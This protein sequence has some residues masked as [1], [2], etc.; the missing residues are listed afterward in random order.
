MIGRSG[1]VIVTPRATSY[2][3]SQSPSGTAS[4]R[5]NK[6]MM[7]Q[8]QPPHRM[9]TPCS[10]KKKQGFFWQESVGSLKQPGAG[11][12]KQKSKQTNIKC[13][14]KM[15]RIRRHI[16]ILVNNR[17]LVGGKVSGLGNGRPNMERGV[18]CV[19]TIPGCL[20]PNSI[21]SILESPSIPQALR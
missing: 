5:Q 16:G 6:G 9:I 8:R 11:K 19:K 1:N 14:A 20:S 12:K 4:R 7:E 15:N 17:K 3:Y 10:E 2:A 21:I 18:I 13:N